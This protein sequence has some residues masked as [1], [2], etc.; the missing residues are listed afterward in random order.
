[1]VTHS[2][3]QHHIPPAHPNFNITMV[4]FDFKVQRRCFD[5]RVTSNSKGSMTINVD[6][7]CDGYGI[8]DLFPTPGEGCMRTR[9]ENPILHGKAGNFHS[10]EDEIL[11]LNPGD[12]NE[13]TGVYW[14]NA[15]DN[16]FKK[17][18]I[19]GDHTRQLFVSTCEL[20]IYVNK[21]ILY[22]NTGKELFSGLDEDKLDDPRFDL[23]ISFYEA[24]GSLRYKFYWKGTTPSKRVRKTEETTPSDTKRKDDRI[25]RF[26]QSLPA[27]DELARATINIQIKKF[28]AYIDRL[29]TYRETLDLME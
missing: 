15:G 5:P 17:G 8:L 20:T 21:G 23:Y 11:F 22:I 9:S 10:G 25:D 19:D 4:H 14:Y 6:R 3:S 7:K 24:E 13:G 2:R 16:T 28:Q 1:M 18:D 27:E 26:I 29:R 12:Y